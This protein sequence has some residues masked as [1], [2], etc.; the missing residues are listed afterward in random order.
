MD[1]FASMVYLTCILSAAPVQPPKREHQSAAPPSWDALYSVVEA[2]QGCFTREQARE[3]G[4]SDQLLQSHL[5]AG[6]IE[7]LHRGIYRL[8]RFPASGRDQEDLVVVWLWSLSAGVFSHETALR[9]HGL[10]DALP[11]RIHLTLTR[12]WEHRRLKPP[13][14]VALYFGDFSTADCTFVGSVPVTTPARS[15]N[16][17]AAAHGDDGVIEAAV[18]QAIQRGLATPASVLPAVE[19]LA[20]STGGAWRVRPEAVADLNGRWLMEVVSGICRKPPPPDWRVEAEDFANAM[21]G[22]L[23]AGKYHPASGTMTLELVWPE[24]ARDTRPSS[25]A[26]RDAAIPRFGWVG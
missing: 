6:T 24:T 26:V 10:S 18:R 2:Q 25:A 3:A 20:Q 14:G 16:D 23:H 1:D 22:R 11:S 8:T 21:A 7:R 17:V 15:I 13:P 4:F 19:Y 9:L 12:D 5:K